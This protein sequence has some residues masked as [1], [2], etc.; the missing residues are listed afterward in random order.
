MLLTFL[1]PKKLF[2]RERNTEKGRS[3]LQGSEP[4][5]VSQKPAVPPKD[6]EQCI[7]L[8]KLRTQ[9]VSSKQD[10][11]LGNHEDYN[12]LSPLRPPR[13]DSSP[14]SQSP[15]RRSYN[16]R[17]R[18]T[19][20]S[21]VRQLR[22]YSNPI[23]LNEACTSPSI[24][25]PPSHS[26]ISQTRT[27]TEILPPE[28]SPVVTLIHAQKLR[29]YVNGTVGVQGIVDGQKAWI[30]VEGKV[31]GCELSIWRPSNDGEGFLSANDELSPKYYNL[32]DTSI[33]VLP[34]N[35]LRLLHLFDNSF[36]LLKFPSGTDAA[37]WLAAITLSKFEYDSLNEAYT[38]VLLSI[39]G[40]KLSDIHVLLSTRKHY[41]KFEW[42]QLRLPQISSKW[43]KLYAA[44]YHGSSKKNGRIE[45]YNSEKLTK[46]NLVIYIPNVWSIFNV[47]PENVN[48]IDLNSIMKLNGEV[49]VNRLYE[50]LFVHNE[51]VS[52]P[53][54]G[55]SNKPPTRS[56]SAS[57][58]SSMAAPN[59]G[60]HSRNASLAS[61]S[62]FFSTAS[63][64]LL[65]ESSKL[66]SPSSS[67]IK[68]NGG[69]YAATNFLYLMPV[70]H[71]GVKSSE[72]MLRNFIHLAD[73]FKLYGRPDHFIAEKKNQ[74][75]LLYGIPSL[76]HYKYISTTSAAESVAS[77]RT[78][79]VN[80]RWKDNEWR[81]MYKDMIASKGSDYKGE[82]NIYKLY[83]NLEMDSNELFSDDNYSP[84]VLL[85]NLSD[86]NSNSP[87]VSNY[88]LDLNSDDYNYHPNGP[89]ESFD[90]KSG[91]V[92][93]DPI[94]FNKPADL[95]SR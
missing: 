92:L 7:E 65:N 90:A 52:S 9:G 47:Y 36:T 44:I 88:K 63:S 19:P 66:R 46:K 32:I 37:K 16:E 33:E 78:V 23:S 49:Y 87:S 18:S 54:L 20:S 73:A 71:P 94:S 41:T 75:S 15:N 67:F 13:I 14:I 58:V 5:G 35:E 74:K 61:A 12:R 91:N 51:G 2:N 8:P 93:G 70:S 10:G 26:L 38:A 28:L 42:Y 68:K 95:S 30:E 1:S 60:S 17:I 56:E 43:V 89:K 21:L 50:Y 22:A 82:G 39:K 62:S 3:K 72:T 45:I 77:I 4:P 48:M 76:P 55:G 40:P 34:N 85:F 83:L 29:T 80:E 53:K 24:K 57:S 25:S 31:C 59:V 86:K 81:K 27:L 6:Q 11:M 84:R 69:N 64:P 79:A